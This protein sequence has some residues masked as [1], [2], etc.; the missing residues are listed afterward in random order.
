MACSLQVTV[1]DDRSPP[2]PLRGRSERSAFR[3][4][5][6][7][8]PTLLSYNSTFPHALASML[9]AAVVLLA[10]Y[11]FGA[12]PFG[13]LIARAKGV[14]LFK[15]GSGNIGATNVGRVLGKKYGIA[16]FVL[17]FLKGT[18]PVGVSVPLANALDPSAG[19]ALG[20][21][22][23][24]RVL[25]GLLAFLGHLFPIYL[26][27]RGGKGVA[28]GAGVVAVLVPGPFAV[29]VAVWLA[30]YAGHAVRFARL[31]G[32]RCHAGGGAAARH[33]ATVR[34]PR[35]NR[36]RVLRRRGGVGGR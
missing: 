18:V 10:S 32:G 36:H 7:P 19:S 6:N 3:V 26:K 30:V 35:V 33:A 34:L 20:H 14:D 24:L 27:F 4:G 29:A 13:Y 9:T 23:A 28:T 31:R 5:G 8:S 1:R 21:P 16:A 25:A 15:A 11:L 12:V 22:D 2:S 17:D